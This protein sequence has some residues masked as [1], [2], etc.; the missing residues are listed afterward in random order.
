MLD[1]R[2]AKRRNVRVGNDP[3]ISE[4]VF[5]ERA[6]VLLSVNVFRLITSESIREI[7]SVF[8]IDKQPE[9]RRSAAADEMRIW[10][11]DY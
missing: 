10:L 2:H 6:S 3:V 11:E 9:L 8:A 1:D 5:Q 4:R 7:K